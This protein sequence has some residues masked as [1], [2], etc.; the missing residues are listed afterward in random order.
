M[1]ITY[2]RTAFA[3]LIGV[4]AAFLTRTDHRSATPGGRVDAPAEREIALAPMRRRELAVSGT[5][6]SDFLLSRAGPLGPYY[7]AIRR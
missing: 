6:G 3:R 1:D 7:G 4:A 2:P 5:N